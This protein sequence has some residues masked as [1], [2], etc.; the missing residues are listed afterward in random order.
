[1]KKITVGL[2]Y[3]RSA[4]Y[5]GIGFDV[6]EAFRSALQHYD[7]QDIHLV[8][9]NVGIGGV[10]SE[11]LAKVE[12]ML[13]EQRPDILVA[14]VDHF[15]AEKIEP[16]CKAANCIL[17]VM[18]TGGTI[19][20]SWKA[21]PGKYHIT[22]DA[23]FGSR[24]TGHMAG[25]ASAAFATSFYDGGYLCC[26]AFTA[27]L[28]DQ[29]GNVCY[30]YVA[31]F[32]FE[33]FD[34][35]PLQQAIETL[36]PGVLLAQMSIDMGALFLET[37]KA[38]GLAGKTKFLASPFLLEEQFLESLAFPFEGITGCVPWSINLDTPGNKEFTEAYTALSG[39]TPTCFAALAWDTCNFALQVAAAI[40]TYPGK[41]AQVLEA[42]K[43]IALTSTRGTMVLDD[44]TNYF[45]APLYA[46]EVVSGENGNAAL[47]TGAE[48][49]GREAAWK[50]FTSEP[51]TG[52][53]S[54]WTNTYLCT[55]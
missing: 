12:K 54:R 29:G 52:V 42:L 48:I 27:G 24:L 37:Y 41:R 50:T 35:K 28:A 16:V 11:V 15:A 51:V 9:E 32:R 17:I 22:L 7:A 43:G 30:N 31:P 49:A 19:P 2:L 6:T 1:M 5:P 47:R 13:I 55:Q 20:V 53:F 33:E 26:N 8:T 10:G 34:I 18:E 36:E 25:D 39:R 45:T 21:V 3:P 4:L 46:A 23:A 38:A 44:E 40:R 14:F